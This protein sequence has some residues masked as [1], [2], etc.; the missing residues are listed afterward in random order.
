MHPPV[1]KTRLTELYG[2]PH[3]IIVGGMMW[4]S[5][6]EFVAACARAGAMAFL[7]AKSYADSDAFRAG[8]IRCLE[9]AD[10]HPFGVNFSIS[11]FRPND[12]V[13][14]G[15][16]IALD[17]GVRHFETAG[18]HPGALIGRIQ[19]AG[20]TV[21]HK[22]TQLRHA[23]KAARDG[24]DALILVGMEAGG[25]PGINPHPGHVMLSNLLK[26]VDIP[27][28][29]GGGIGTGA[30]VFGALAQGADA[31]LLATRFLGANEMIVHENYKRH[32]GQ[33]GMDDT[34]AVLHSIKDT[35]RVLRNDTAMQVAAMERAFLARETPPVHADFGELV[36]GD[37]ARRNAYV[38]GDMQV[39]LMSCS[40][41]IAHAP[42]GQGGGEIV[43]QLMAE[44]AQARQ[45]LVGCFV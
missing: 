31:A 19:D 5:R 35:W 1:F 22:S 27:V 28:A 11:R 17:L 45:R 44:A 24:V 13:E 26:E 16:E 33:A 7:T 25:H 36:K 20:G 29:L 30:Q 38:T 3:P 34:M 32:M 39:G 23:V 8:L 9:L 43:D 12:I 42:G 14:E 10:G 41:A 21:I 4:F 40:A 37:Y 15:I 18:S 2:V 6:A